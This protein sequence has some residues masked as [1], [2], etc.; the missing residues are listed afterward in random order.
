VFLASVHHLLLKGDL[1][2]LSTHY[3]SVCERRGIE[4]REVDDATLVAA[5]ASFCHE[6]E[7]ALIE[8][9]ATRA[10]Q[11]NEVGRC[12]VLRAVLADLGARETA[13]GLLD[14]GCSAG[15]NLFV[16]AYAYD[17]GSGRIGPPGAVPLLTCE[18]RGDAPPIDVPRVAARV[19]LDLSPVDAR[20]DDAV[21]W[22]LA[23]LWPDGLERF[24]R[25]GLAAGVAA[26]RS[27]ELVLVRGD[28]VDDL[29]R[30][31]SEVADDVRLVVL[32]CWSAA[33]LPRPQRAELA[34]TIAA[35]AA[36]RPLTWVTME[37]PTVAQDLGVLARDVTLAP[38]DA[39]VVCVSEFGGGAIRSALAAVTHA[40]GVWMSWRGLAT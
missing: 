36:T 13:V 11:T 6:H 32:D 10:T 18:L 20:D 29:E 15:L 22:L 1:H 35:L 21:D 30:A 8:S 9:C 12:A 19:G 34:A 14:L 40:H 38:P 27:E 7:T 4:Y 2:P 25:L 5:F 17:Y 26:A 24:D 16:D 28:M 31:A 37:G 3:R 39:S 33:Y 23:C